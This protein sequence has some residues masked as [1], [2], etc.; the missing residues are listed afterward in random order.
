MFA[1]PPD[2]SAAWS[3]S[4]VEGASRYLPSFVGDWLRNLYQRLPLVRRQART[5]P[6]MKAL[7]FEVHSTFEAN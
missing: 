2:Q 6:P 7:R 1:G 4:G 3:S 5:M